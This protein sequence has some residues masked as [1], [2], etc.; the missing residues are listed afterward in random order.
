MLV[1]PV[2]APSANQS[3]QGAASP[4]TWTV[5]LVTVPADTEPEQ[6]LPAQQEFVW[7]RRPSFRFGNLLRLDL[8]LK[9]QGD[10]RRTYEGAGESADLSAFELH[11]RRIGVSGT[12]LRRI[13]FE[14][15]R[16]L[17]TPSLTPA[18]IASE[19]NTA[20]PWKDVYVDLS[21]FRSARVRG[22]RFKIP[23]GLDALTSAT[24]NDFVYRSL[25]AE[26]LAPS[27][28]VGIML[29]GRFFD[30]GLSY[31]S[32]AFRHDGD[33][34]ASKS[35]RGGDRTLAA[36]VAARPLGRVNRALFG[37]LEAATAF[38]VSTVRDDS[39]RPNGLRARTVVSED[40]FFEPVYVSGHR[41]RWEADVDWISGPA[42]LRAEYT[43][44]T[45]DRLRQGI[46]GD[47]L[48]DARYRAWYVSG[49]YLL[50]GQAKSRPVVPLRGIFDGAGALEVAA[51]LERIWCDSIGT[52]GETPLAGPRA[53][54]ILQ[55]GGRVITLGINW[56]P[57][58]WVT[59]HVNAIRERV[60][61]AA[62][63]PVPLGG[64]F[65]SQVVR[66][67]FAF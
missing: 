21:Y 8:R 14:V 46:A 22:G 59:V 40:M 18:E 47:D 50:T 44:V 54:N 35:S 64:A 25:G 49:S 55:N 34:A 63:S 3:R 7:D 10:L 30:R 29:H 1:V 12:L 66:F 9:L 28:D 16:E 38:T 33:N 27:R 67:Q 17:T 58:R 57:N 43:R 32:G 20:T 65:W 15:E 41:W 13:E 2:H 26:Y 52:S 23:F 48:A 19:L 31:W 11:R 61:D 53:R 6:D 24:E 51:R 37:S 39:F 42:S 45:D 5:A 56:F 36:R 4:P 62:R 60:E